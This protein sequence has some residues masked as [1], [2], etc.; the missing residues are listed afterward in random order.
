MWHNDE[1]TNKL[2]VHKLVA[3]REETTNQKAKFDKVKK[4]RQDE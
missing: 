3:A 1:H 2:T 4:K